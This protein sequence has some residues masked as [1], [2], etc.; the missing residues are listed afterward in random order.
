MALEGSIKDFG[1][2]D[3]LQLIYFQRKS[4]VLYLDGKAD[5]VK[6]FFVN[7]NVI[8]AESRRRL[9][10]NKLGK[11]LV[12]RGIIDQE[13][14]NSALQQQNKQGEKLGHILLEIGVA[15]EAL[16]GII[17]EQITEAVTQ[18]MGWKQ[19]TY[20]FTPQ[21]INMDDELPVSID[22]QH[23][24]MEGLRIVDEWSLIE[25]KLNINTIYRK[26][27]KIEKGQLTHEEEDIL[28]L[29]D[30]ERDVSAII[31]ES[32]MGDFETSRVIV[33]LEEKGIIEPIE[34]A[35]VIPEIRAEKK[36]FS[37]KYYI[38][39]I[40]SVI[41]FLGWLVYSSQ[42]IVDATRFVKAGNDIEDLRLFIEA[43]KFSNGAYPASI[44]RPDPWGRPYVYR[45]TN[46]GFD[47]YSLGP[48]Q[49]S[50]GGEIY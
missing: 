21:V 40:L 32:D 28:R 6:L 41:L 2:A 30:E 14:L 46:D 9:E 34:L 20:E 25:G 29:I 10:I 15:K 38:P 17:E 42:G 23:L 35:A 27:K 37:P 7:G 24:L 44:N 43:Y 50:T 11:V 22:T 1:L 16:M 12:K 33:S 47:L 3:I 36:G 39:V 26:T 31:E 45:V 5:K 19:G 4:G 48:K 8:S 13:Q 18:I 49:Q